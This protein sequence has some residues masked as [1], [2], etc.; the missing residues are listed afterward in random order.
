MGRTYAAQQTSGTRAILITCLVFIATLA[1]RTEE[2]LPSSEAA[3]IASGV[4]ALKSGDVD[5][6]DRIFNDALHRGIKHPLILHNLGVIAQE[7]GN[8]Q[9]AVTRFHQALLMQPN[10]GPARLLLGSS[11]LALG[12][13]SEATHELGRA[14]LLMPKEPAARL[15]LAKAYE[16][17]EKWVEAVDQLQQLTRLAPENQ[18]YS[19]QLGKALTK[20]S[21]WSLEEI[22]RANPDSARLHQALGQD[23]LMQEKYDQ[24]LEAYKKAARSN[25]N[26]PEVHL[27]MAL[28]LMQLKRF[29]E[30][31]NEIEAELKLVPDSKAAL[32]AKAKIE[33]AKPTTTP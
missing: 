24:A 23:Y 26:L 27:G 1:V 19:Y 29:D 32:D 14:V 22:S 7:R 9:L 8:H 10:Y 13:N 20:L 33:A 25:P 6:A 2:S 12:K 18:E 5:N 11:L 17:Q 16:A 30:A 28:I 15:E 4:Q 21:A 3:L 31:L